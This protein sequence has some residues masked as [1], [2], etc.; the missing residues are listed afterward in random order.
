MA[1]I[2]L[3]SMDNGRTVQVE[4]GGQVVIHLAENPATGYT[5]AIDQMDVDRLELLHDEH[6]QATGGG[7]GAGGVHVWRLMVCLTG[8]AH[9]SFKLWRD[10]EGDESVIERYEVTLEVLKK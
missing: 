7:Y 5:W 4:L 2:E 1:V 10:W 9:V 6:Q 3:T 8:M